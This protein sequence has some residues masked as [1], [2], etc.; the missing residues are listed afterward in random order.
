MQELVDRDQIRTDLSALDDASVVEVGEKA[1]RSTREECP[2]RLL[3]QLQFRRF[4]ILT[5]LSVE[6][7]ANRSSSKEKA[8][9]KT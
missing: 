9:D 7:G 5:V 6:P 3:L 1:T 8:S 2:A 4:H